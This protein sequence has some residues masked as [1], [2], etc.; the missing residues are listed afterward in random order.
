[1]DSQ[2]YIKNRYGVPA[3]I[4][5][6]IL[7]EDRKGKIVGFVDSYIKAVFYD[8]KKQREL[9]LHPT[10]NVVYLETFNTNQIKVKNPRSRERYSH[11]LSLDLDMSFLQYLKS[12]YCI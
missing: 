5:R 2:E 1:M 3:D 6:E 10:S 7:F 9:P 8:D 11:Y 12:S 4:N